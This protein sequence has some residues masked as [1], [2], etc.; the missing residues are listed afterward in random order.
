MKS[1]PKPFQKNHLLILLLLNAFFLA[2]PGIIKAQYIAK[3]RYVD[4]L[5][6]AIPYAN[7]LLLNSLD[8]TLVKGEI[9]NGSG[10]FSLAT[11]KGGKFLVAIK[12][13]GYED[14][15]SK[16]INL[17]EANPRIELGN[18]IPVEISRQLDAVVIEAEKPLFE[19]KIDRT[20]IN[21]QSS[22][23]SSGGSVLE[24]LARSPGV[25]VDRMNMAVSLAGKQGVRF[26]INGKIS[27]IPLEAV[28]QML[29]G[30]SAENIEKIELITTPPA[31]YEAAGDAGL[32]NI[33]LKQQTDAGTNG[34]LSLFSGYGRMEKY[35]GNINFNNRSKKVN[36]Y[37]DYSFNNNVS[38]ALW[39][40]NR[41]V[42]IAGDRFQI[43]NE[44]NRDSYTRI[45]SGRF[46]A[47]WN[48]S[49]KTTVG[50]IISIFD[51]KWEMDA[52][53]NIKENIN[54]QPSGIIEMGT[55]ELNKWTTLIGNLNLMHAF[56]D[57]HSISIDI[58]H[59]DYVSDNPTDYAQRNYNKSLELTHTS[60]LRSRKETPINTWV[61]TIDYTKK[62]DKFT[63]EAGAKG[64][65]SSLR[66]DIMVENIENGF[67]SIDEEL[68]SHAEM[69]ENIGAGYASAT[70]DASNKIHLK[71]GLRYEHTITKINTLEEGN[72]VDR[73]FG[74]FFPSFF[75]QNTINKNNSW[76]F[77]YSRRITRPSFFQIAPFVIFM[78]PY[79]FMS[80]NISLLPAMTDAVKA[81]YRYQSILFSLQ[82]SHDKNS[83]SIFQP[84]IME[85][86]R[87]VNMAENMDYR[88]NVSANL[89][90]PFS[91]TK[92]WEWQLNMSGNLI[93]I[94]TD[95]L[96]QPVDL[97]I[98]NFTFNG[99]QNFK[100]P[101]NFTAE[102]SGFY[103]SKQ[104]FG[105]MELKAF[106]GV[107]FGLEK[108]FQHSQLRLAISD[109][110]NTNNWNL[111]TTIPEENLD[112]RLFLDFET[113][114]VRV[115]Y[116]TSFGN[117][118]LKVKKRDATG[119][120][121]EQRRFR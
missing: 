24:V 37:G 96:E 106:G 3:G 87:Q 7:V 4:S 115:T 48:I 45:H 111:I 22:I 28:I 47:D 72:V 12:F 83:I 25:T 101:N 108:K 33:V 85:D 114:V 13:I 39:A 29:D 30:M 109:L 90:L 40:T 5:E 84:R 15:F 56:N 105:V 117:R 61:G 112:T 46:G 118:K 104:L 98:K 10:N 103:Q 11:D 17:S 38:T 62:S 49:K 89:S 88:N 80:G 16:E 57:R 73:N 82:Y 81:E 119:S 78:D 35:G 97:T 120:E 36:L 44:N 100:L 19:Q 32:I 9:T 54:Y 116:S 58:D 21:V 1:S 8:S 53:A 51:R 70:I 14:Y 64:S 86:G 50:G 31:K 23:A 2:F 76:V 69:I 110:F 74:G 63:F 93:N 26:M 59:I 66:N 27:Q 52:L 60:A 68:T 107:D 94:K 113:R 67:V 18:I 77:S 92:W 6:T 102:I 91:I 95:Y 34:N 55:I 71:F 41:V 121:E 42:N 99:T 75:F 20:V 43:D 65:F 79:N